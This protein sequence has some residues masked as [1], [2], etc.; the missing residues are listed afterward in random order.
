MLIN[1]CDIV[2]V[3]CFICCIIICIQDKILFLVPCCN[4]GCFGHKKFE[5]MGAF[6]E[7]MADFCGFLVFFVLVGRKRGVLRPALS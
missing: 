5:K 7:K 1:V 4:F 2:D 6:C 3:N